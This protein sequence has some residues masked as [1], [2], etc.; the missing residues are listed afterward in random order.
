MAFLTLGELRAILADPD[1]GDEL[2]VVLARDAE[3]NGFR[4][5][6][7]NDDE[8][9][10]SH[11]TGYYDGEDYDLIVEPEPNEHGVV[12]AGEASNWAWAKENA[13]ACIVLWPID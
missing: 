9:I 1:L 11:S 7:A 12:D 2:I 3:G 5:V 6:G 13:V 8:V 4:P 10:Y